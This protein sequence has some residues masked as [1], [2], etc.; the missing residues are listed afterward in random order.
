MTNTLTMEIFVYPDR[1]LRNLGIDITK[2]GCDFYFPLTCTVLLL[3]GGAWVALI[4]NDASVYDSK[5]R[6]RLPGPK[7]NL[8]GKNFF[9]V[10]RKARKNFQGTKAM[11]EILLPAYGDGNFMASNLFGRVVTIIGH[12]DYCRSVLSASHT[13]F[14]K[15][16]RYNRLKFFLGDGLVTSSGEKWKSHRN[17]ISDGFHAEALKE[18][19]IMFSTHCNGYIKKWKSQCLRQGSTTVKIDAN[20]E[21]WEMTLKIICDAAF[22]YQID[23]Q[24]ISLKQYF[25][26][27][28]DEMNNKLLDPTEW[29][30][31]FFPE[32]RKKA[33]IALNKIYSLINHILRKR[34]E[35]ISRQREGVENTCPGIPFSLPRKDLLDFLIQARQNGQL[36]EKELR[37]HSLTFFAAGHETTSTTMLWALY[38]IARSPKVMQRCHEEVDEV[39]LGHDDESIISYEEIGRLGYLAQTVKETLRRHPPAQVLARECS[40]E[41]TVGPYTLAAKTNFIICVLAIHHHPDFWEKPYEF[42]PDRFAPE[43]SKKSIKHPFQYIPFSAGPRNCEYCTQN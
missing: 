2:N 38:E 42:N 4:V 33:K 27:I 11:T 18:M 15:A 22:G 34:L 24:D 35:G 12:P 23:L 30:S 14:P 7:S 40:E 26:D 5:T 28:G 41:V 19:I 9:S 32:R 17:I 21:L 6:E 1:I 13:K 29:W 3:L 16:S 8:W 39:L 20:T 36:N 10:V 43:T 31:I 25:Y 37:D